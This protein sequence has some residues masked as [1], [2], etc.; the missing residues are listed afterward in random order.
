M[1]ESIIYK[2]VQP[3]AYSILTRFKHTSDDLEF[4]ETKEEDEVYREI[5]NQYLGLIVGGHKVF[6]VQPYIKWGRDKKRNT[7]PMLQMAE[8]VALIESLPY[9]SVVD[10]TFAPLMTFQKKSLL[11]SG[12]LKNLRD[13]INQSAQEITAIFVST[14]LLKHVQIMELQNILGLPVF[15]RYSIV[16]HIFRQHAKTPEA[17]LQVAL[18]EL[19][20]IWQKMVEVDN[21]RGGQINLLE[22][23]KKFLRTRE[24]K[25]KKTLEKLKERR[26][27]SRTRRKTYGFP[28][29]A[30]VGYTNAGKTSLIKALTGDAS[31][32]PRNQ[33]F[34][35]LDT[36]SYEGFLP[37]R[38]K[39]LYMD[40]IGFIQ[41]VPE[42]L[43]EP[44]VVTLED[45]IVSDV[46]VHV[47]DI[48]HP[49]MQ[50]Q[51][52]HVQKT[53][54]PMLTEQQSVINVANKCD[55]V[56][57]LDIPEDTIAI[58]CKELTGI[59]E[60]KQKLEQEVLKA[61]G[62]SVKRI[63]VESGSL[64]A[65]WLYKWTTVINSE[66]DDNNPQYMF[67]D[68]IATDNTIREF[69]QFLKQ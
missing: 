11:G 5:S 62:R 58:S 51:F 69:K 31:L 60:L 10:K 67:L 66:P 13:K 57:D 37:S 44:F 18:A 35:T 68:V 61:S 21:K 23:R 45:A 4:L 65:T 40:T 27:E 38:Q 9:W 26:K 17:Q 6:L 24:S 1:R 43:L 42:M 33:L 55:L 64:A 63:R 15:D 22:V 49:D 12:A 29:I 46:V 39:V 50:A 14:N 47:Y 36:I 48:S 32:K 52:Q 53:I 54:Q 8:S 16:I 3:L 20:Y 34:A 19:P 56:K 30:V 2:K 25:L 41:D 59:G 7:T 28:S